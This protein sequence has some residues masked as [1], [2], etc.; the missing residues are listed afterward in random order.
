MA[1][2]DK[3]WTPPPTGFYMTDA[4]ADHAAEF[5]AGTSRGD[6]PFF[7]STA[8]TAPHFRLMRFRMALQDTK[9]ST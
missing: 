2:D 3:P 8:F 1:L 5:M 4:I 6:Q 9:G 7:V